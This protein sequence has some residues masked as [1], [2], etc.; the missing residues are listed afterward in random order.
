M[1]ISKCYQ[2]FITV[3][4]TTFLLVTAAQDYDF[5]RGNYELIYK[6]IEWCTTSVLE[7]T[8]CLHFS[9]AVARDQQNIVRGFAFLVNCT[10]AFSKDECMS[11]LDDEK[12]TLTTLD[13]G[14]VFTAGRFHS[15]VPI[16]KEVTE[17]GG[18]EY[19]SVAVIK[20]NSLQDVTSLRDL[21]G[22]RAC[23]PGVGTMAGWVLPIHILI[24]EAGMEIID[25]N[26]IVKTATEFF[27]PS[28]A[29]NALVDANNPIGDNPDKLCQLCVGKIPGGKCTDA[30]PY[31]GYDGAFRC[32]LESGDVAFLRDTTVLELMKGTGFSGISADNFEL[33]CKD[34]TRAPIG[35]A[36]RCN[37]GRIP[38]NAIVV[39]SA[40]TMKERL[41]YQQFLNKVAE[42]YADDHQGNVNRPPN[43]LE[44]DQFGNRV[45]NKRQNY[46]SYN[47]ENPYSNDNKQNNYDKKDPF[48]NNNNNRERDRTYED[49]YF[50]NPSRFGENI[51]PYGDLR[52]DYRGSEKFDQPTNF[53]YTDKYET[54]YLFQSSPKYGR[55]SNLMFQDSTKRFFAIPENEQTYD[56]YLKEL[57]SVVVGIRSCP[58]KS[59]TLCVTSDV[60]MEKCIKM[61]IALKAQL[62]KPEM[63]CYKAHSQIKCM[64]AIQSRS[65]DVAVFDAGDIYTA[66]LKYEL[67][68]FIS[69]LYN[70]GSPDY[71]V[72]A[73]AKETDPD[74]DLTYLRTKNT[75]HGGVNTGAGWVYPLAFLISNGWIRPYGCNSMRAAA[76]Y[77]TKSCVPGALSNEYNTGVPYDN[78]CDLCRGS[79]FRY[80]R[81]D[82]SEMFYGHTGAFRCLVE[83]GGDVAFVKHTTAIEN[84]GGKRREW[85][86][87]DALIDDFELLCPDG[88]RAEV[89][90]YLK[91]N[92]GK[93]KANAIVTRGGY[94]YNETEVNAFINLF[95]Y[96]QTL[97]GGK[98]PDEFSFSMFYSPPPYT[99]LIFQD[100][101]TQLKVIPSHLREYSKYL[102]GDFM[103]AKRIVDC[104]AGAE[105]FEITLFTSILSLIIALYVL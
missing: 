13:A 26:N 28:C 25:C 79:S 59:M 41:L 18:T 3:I 15:L 82:A 87:R 84:T 73:V 22:R 64:A 42:L 39:S 65:A 38:T 100:A 58:V 5:V 1:K 36:T 35:Q 40:A 61:K 16:A 69:E 43:D 93:V 66:G 77:F 91:C 6:R 95:L 20:R 30:D 24:K 19:Y 67:I 51:D 53:Q 29:V 85:W 101:T 57:V 4:I 78:M 74:T 17:L 52:P 2:C 33:L 72:V 45:R 98:I 97:Y 23:F 27:G 32:L 104:H 34:G 54:F 75:C 86:A 48:D 21:R 92:L 62:L 7:Q 12:V 102:G 76:E 50:L 90:E 81:R 103:R 83:G 10:Q 63:I 68:P 89:N 99:D 11:L 55:Q 80:C 46:N 105:R 88:T 94:D 44:Y 96:S 70:L 60:E 37:W 9:E 49:R 14:Q 8:K 56:G 47:N 31:A 71:Y